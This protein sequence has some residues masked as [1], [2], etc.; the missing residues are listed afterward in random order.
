VPQGSNA[1]QPARRRR[2][3]EIWNDFSR[4]CL[5]PTASPIQR[6]EMRKAFFVGAHAMLEAMNTAMDTPEEA[7]VLADLS[8][9]ME[10]FRLEILRAAHT[11]RT[12][13]GDQFVP[14]MSK[15]EER[16]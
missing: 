8:A 6:A 9:E 12:K 13:S 1:K 14:V 4:M 5:A 3:E 10:A 15:L 11:K 7:T 2:L 16:Q